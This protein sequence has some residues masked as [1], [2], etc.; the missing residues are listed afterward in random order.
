MIEYNSWEFILSLGFS[1]FS[2]GLMA[3]NQYGVDKAIV[4]LS[5]RKRRVRVVSGVDTQVTLFGIVN[6]GVFSNTPLVLI[7]HEF[8][9]IREGHVW[10]MLVSGVVVNTLLFYGIFTVEL[11]P[12]FFGLMLNYSMGL[13][14]LRADYMAIKKNGYGAISILIKSFKEEL[15]VYSVRYQNATGTNKFILWFGRMLDYHPSIWF[16]EWFLQV[17]YKG[18]KM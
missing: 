12:I 3:Y 16:R 4:A 6:I 18:I 14:E 8:A 9:H 15:R 2:T 1:L 7:S 11:A 10:I 17:T 5:G 13:L